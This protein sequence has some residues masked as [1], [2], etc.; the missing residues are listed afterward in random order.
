MRGKSVNNQ[1]Y[2]GSR[3]QGPGVELDFNANEKH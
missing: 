3:L 2:F 1:M